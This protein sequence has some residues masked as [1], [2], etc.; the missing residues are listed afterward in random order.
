VGDVVSH[1]NLNPSFERKVLWVG[2][3]DIC[4]QHETDQ[5]SVF[6][7]KD[8]TLIRKAP[9]RIELDAV[10]FFID[11]LHPERGVGVQ[12]SGDL[13]VKLAPT[14]YKAVFTEAQ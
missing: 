10:R 4:V 13:P 1:K 14:K 5:P 9:E 12:F 11:P 8:F 3:Q 2:V 6:N 7:K